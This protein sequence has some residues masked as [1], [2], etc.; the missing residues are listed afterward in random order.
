MPPF[1]PLL[2]FLLG[3]FIG[4]FANVVIL[5]LH[6]GKKGILG[7]RSECPKCHHTL[8]AADLFPVFSWLF[9]RGKC[10]YCKKPISAQYPIV[11]FLMGLAWAGTYFIAP[12]DPASSCVEYWLGLGF[13]ELVVTGLLIITVYDLKYF[14]IPDEVSIPL[15][16]LILLALP[17]P[18]TPNFI[19]A[20][21]GAAIPL[22]FFS[23]QIL[24]SKGK[25]MG[26]GDLRLGAI[27][28]LL[29]GWK[30]TLVALF[31][32]YF[33]GAII[34]LFLMS[35]GKKEKSSMIPFGPFLVVGTV[36]GLLYGHTVAVWYL[37]LIGVGK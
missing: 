33:I 5:R 15:I 1:F 12:Y 9:L 8:G 17:F 14:E 27:M 28:G 18:F 23:L 7:G 19:D 6:S 21:I 11:E 30:A 2:L 22:A 34:G 26:G 25:W 29:L 24:V 20:L 4:S 37:G 10:R 32:S 13:F 35:I 3:L 36:L 31:F 16:I